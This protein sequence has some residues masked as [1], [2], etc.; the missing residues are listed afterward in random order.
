MSQPPVE[1]D[2]RVVRLNVAREVQPGSAEWV[3]AAELPAWVAANQQCR[4]E[5]TGSSLANPLWSYPVVSVADGNV[6]LA[7]LLDYHQLSPR[8][9]ST[10]V[11]TR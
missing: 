9:R 10:A 2:Y 3:V 6:T 5:L 7:T 11:G 4:L 1:L 8:A